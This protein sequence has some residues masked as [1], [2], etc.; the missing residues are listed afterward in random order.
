MGLFTTEEYRQAFELAG[1][2]PEFDAH[3]LIGRGLWVAQR[4]SS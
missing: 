4:T 3:G 1:L 2:S